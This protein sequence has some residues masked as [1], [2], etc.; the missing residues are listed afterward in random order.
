MKS[1]CCND[2]LISIPAEFH[3]DYTLQC[4]KCGQ[5]FE[6]VQWDGT[7]ASDSGETFSEWATIMTTRMNADPMFHR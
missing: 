6:E 1:I 2:W 5:W 3:G 7:T 4:M